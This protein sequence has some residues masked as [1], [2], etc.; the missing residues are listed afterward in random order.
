[1]N[2]ENPDD[3]IRWPDIP[4]DI[5]PKPAR[6]YWGVVEPPS[7]NKTQKRQPKPAPVEPKKVTPRVDPDLP[8]L[9]YGTEGNIKYLEGTIRWLASQPDPTKQQS[10]RLRQF[11]ELLAALQATGD[12]IQ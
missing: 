8:V 9:R 11:K 3:D 5:K 12:T 2:N 7:P 4:A 10:K 1:M 6:D